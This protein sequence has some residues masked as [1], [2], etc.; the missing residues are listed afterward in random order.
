MGVIE[1]DDVGKSPCSQS[2]LVVDVKVHVVGP[3]PQ[4]DVVQECSRGSSQSDVVVDVHGSRRCARHPSQDNLESSSPL[5]RSLWRREVGKG[6]KAG[7][8]FT[9]ECTAWWR[10]YI[11]YV[12]L[13]LGS[14][15]YW[16]LDLTLRE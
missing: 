15:E 11:Y 16:L 4:V 7:G 1:A 3:K 14:R 6:K 10:V 13:C 8:V 12:W 2:T 9:F 5:R